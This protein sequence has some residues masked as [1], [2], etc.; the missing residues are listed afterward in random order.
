MLIPVVDKIDAQL[1]KLLPTDVR[2]MYYV[3][4]KGEPMK[5]NWE[6]K[7]KFS[8]REKNQRKFALKAYA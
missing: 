2:N 7:P 4:E 1:V 8:Q 6:I 5:I 3:P